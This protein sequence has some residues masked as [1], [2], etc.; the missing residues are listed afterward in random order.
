M[1]L[2]ILNFDY[3]Y[4]FILGILG[5]LGVT[6]ILVKLFDLLSDGGET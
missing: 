1:Y 2:E 4:H 3:V 5:F 6:N